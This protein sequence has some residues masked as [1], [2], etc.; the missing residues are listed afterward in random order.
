MVYFF[1]FWILAILIFILYFISRITKSKELKDIFDNYGGLFFIVIGTFLIMAILTKDLVT[2][3]GITVPMELQWLGSLL[4]TGFGTWKFYLNPLKERVINVEK[5]VSSI[6]A[7]IKSSFSSIKED[8]SLIKN[9]LI[10]K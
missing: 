9:K 3:M 2:I 10:G 4:I 6:N 7:E 5:D 8:L 1:I